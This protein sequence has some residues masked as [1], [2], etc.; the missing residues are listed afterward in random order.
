MD[1]NSLETGKNEEKDVP[2]Q[3]DGA[4]IWSQLLEST[5]DILD[6]FVKGLPKYENVEGVLETAEKAAEKYG[7]IPTK[8]IEK[9]RAQDA[10]AFSD[11]FTFSSVFT[12]GAEILNGVAD[13]TDALTSERE[14][15]TNKILISLSES[16]SITEG[17]ISIA[18][19]V[20]ETIGSGASKVL[21]KLAPTAKITGGTFSVT[22]AVVDL[23]EHPGD[24][25]ET[26][27]AWSNLAAGV[28][29]VTGGFLEL[30]VAT[31]PLAIPLGI[32]SSSF[33]IAA[34]FFEEGN[35]GMGLLSIAVGIVATTIISA[36]MK[37]VLKTA[38]KALM[39]LIK[40]AFQ[41]TLAPLL[42]NP[43]T[44]VVAFGVGILVGELLSS[45]LPFAQGGF[46]VRDH[47]FIA[48]EAGPEL[49][50][51]LNGR[52]AVVNNDQIVQ[53]V[54][55]GVSAAFL[56]ACCKGGFGGGVDVE[57]YMDGRRLAAAVC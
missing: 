36:F 9:I 57:V 31:A 25:K 53:S 41:T 13:I 15:T 19:A 20:K 16:S 49:V 21:G 3:S 6:F 56:A 24:L 7:V 17:I 50:G 39:Q 28:L 47:T 40:T 43:V 8:A 14:S 38:F 30:G 2:A 37:S 54:S 4:P 27:K 33:S 22:N 10:L 18:N 46:P 48:R 29:D 23:N 11:A 1:D 42:A 26:T 52:N 32:L 55:R 45:T 35:W 12:S 5:G 44:A 51:T 34:G